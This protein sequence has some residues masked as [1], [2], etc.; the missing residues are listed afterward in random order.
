MI[1]V[2][3]L[4]VVCVGDVKWGRQRWLRGESGTFLVW[5]LV[6]S[7]RLFIFLFSCI[8]HVAFQVRFVLFFVSL[9]APISPPFPSPLVLI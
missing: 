6:V 1:G 7:S 5:D 4:A 2:P 3:A 8:N 9:T